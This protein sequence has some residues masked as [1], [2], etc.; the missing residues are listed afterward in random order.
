VI[1]AVHIFRKDVRHLWPEITLHTA[2][3]ITFAWAA[4]QIW[5]GQADSLIQILVGL[6]RILLPIL[7]LVIISRL[8]H[9]ESLV[10]DQ[11]FWIT[12]PYNWRSLLSAKLLFLTAFIFLPFLAMQCFLLVHAGIPP[13]AEVPNLLA[14]LL[15][16]IV[17]CFLPVAVL[18]AVTSTLSRF[19]VSVVA[20]LLYVMVLAG[21]FSYFLG[22]RSMPSFV[23]PAMGAIFGIVCAGILLY[24]YATRHTTQA[25][26]AL[27]VT[28]AVIALMVLVVPSS[29]FYRRAYAVPAEAGAPRLT[30]DSDPSRRESQLGRPYVFVHTMLLNV[31]TQ[32]EGLDPNFQLDGRSVSFTMAAPGIHY[33]SSWQNAMFT[34]R[35][36]TLRVPQDLV[37]RSHDAAVHLH[38]SVAAEEFAAGTPENI[39]TTDRFRGPAGASCLFPEEQ[40]GGNPV[41]RFALRIPVTTKVSGAFSQQPCF[42][43]SPA[44]PAPAPAP[45]L[46]GSMMMRATPR[47]P[48]LDPIVQVPVRLADPRASLGHPSNTFVCVGGPLTFTPYHSAGN[49]RLELDVPG[50]VL[51]DYISHTG[52]P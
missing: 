20:A 13:L 18:A 50:I 49:L 44:A 27:G 43:A 9:D 25:R 34:R 29:P 22:Y 21:G 35:S 2:I 10:G 51:N 52:R 30:F 5:L 8:V 23:N 48:M 17:L 14:N 37:D 26:I 31:P 11:Q 6:L 19:A 3:L 40:I 47:F 45:G 42:A 16:L 33:E 4:P 12:R 7:W 15:Y 46:V 28:P 32:L 38:L 1:Q 36:V 41:C 39:V 24:Q